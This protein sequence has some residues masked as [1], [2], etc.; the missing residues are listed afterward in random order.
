MCVMEIDPGT[1]ESL[2]MES[3]GLHLQGFLLTYAPRQTM[4]GTETSPPRPSQVP[5]CIFLLNS[6]NSLSTE[7]IAIMVFLFAFVFGLG[8]YFFGGGRGKLQDNVFL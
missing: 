4:T 3:I 1:E 6:L 2:H 5:H 8:G 7:G